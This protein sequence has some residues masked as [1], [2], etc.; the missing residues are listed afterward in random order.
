M[1]A[2]DIRTGW[3]SSEDAEINSVVLQTLFLFNVST[4]IL[5]YF[6]PATGLFSHKDAG[7]GEVA[8]REA[9]RTVKRLLE[10]QSDKP[11]A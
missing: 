10:K 8:T 11:S 2:M 5:K 1:V 3:V 9:N 4:G 7:I 6:S